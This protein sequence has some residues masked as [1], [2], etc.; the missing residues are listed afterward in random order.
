MKL[1]WVG[2]A[3]GAALGILA[4]RLVSSDQFKSGIEAACARIDRALSKA[5]EITS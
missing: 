3:T 2:V 4:H 1:F 5:I